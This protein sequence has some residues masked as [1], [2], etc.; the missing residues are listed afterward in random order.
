M[1]LRWS[2]AAACDIP[3]GALIA[4]AT[5]QAPFRPESDCLGNPRVYLE[6]FGL[7]QLGGGLQRFE[8]ELLHPRLQCRPAEAAATVGAAG[9]TAR[10]PWQR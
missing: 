4:S 3:P 8:E 6:V 10:S 7:H 5:P 2:S 1:T 9:H